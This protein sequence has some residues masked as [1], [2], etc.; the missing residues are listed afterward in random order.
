MLAA[1][2]ARDP[3]DRDALR[4]LADRNAA[5]ERWDAVADAC[6][7]LLELEEGEARLAVALRLAEACERAGDAVGVREGLEAA[8]RASPGY[9]PVRAKLRA[10]YRALGAWRDLAELVLRDAAEA[11]DDATRFERLREAGELLVHSAGD[12][13]SAIAPLEQALKLRPGDHETTLALADAYIAGGYIAEASQ[14]LDTAIAAYKGRRTREVAALQYRMA[15]AAN[16]A[17]DRNVELAWLN[18]ALDSD[19]Q[20]GQVASELADLAIEF[21]QTE[22]ALKALRAVTLMK[23]P[24]PM[25]RGMAFF[26]QGVIA[27]QQGDSRKAVFL[28]KRALSEEP[29]LGDAQRFLKEIGEA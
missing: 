26:R 5:A 11:R 19:L 12:A 1:W 8:H 6:R 29:G 18:A 2:V 13:A 20:N 16:A 27:F 23:N 22:I 28:V 21:G 3:G 14:L 4:M 17:G 9:E 15:R 24:G 10:L 25:T 7:R